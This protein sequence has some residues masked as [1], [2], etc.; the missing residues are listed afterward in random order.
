MRVT[1]IEDKDAKALIDRLALECHNR[2]ARS[3]PSQRD[4]IVA[5]HRMFHYVVTEWF[6][7][8]GVRFYGDEINVSTPDTRG[9]EGSE[10]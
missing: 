2:K 7:Q 8:Q 10:G 1:I 3:D 5:A 9:R 4:S 6:Q